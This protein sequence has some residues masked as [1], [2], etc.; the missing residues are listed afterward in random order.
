MHT[1]DKPR[2]RL[3]SASES[4]FES[5]S[6]KNQEVIIWWNTTF[7]RGLSKERTWAVIDF[8]RTTTS[9]LPVDVPIADMY[10]HAY[11][12]FEDFKLYAHERMVPV[13]EG[14]AE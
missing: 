7:G 5:L 10:E 11:D 3:K 14:G 4:W 9:K 13:S 8:H 6:S 12:M 1:K 2:F